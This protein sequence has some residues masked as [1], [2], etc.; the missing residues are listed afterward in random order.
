MGWLAKHHRNFGR[1]ALFAMAL[2]LIAAFGHIHAT[3]TAYSPA[4]STI[5]SPAPDHDDGAPAT[6][7]CAICA[8]MHLAGTLDLPAVAAVSAP[9]TTALAWSPPADRAIAPRPAASFRARGPPQA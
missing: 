1:L 6:T 4:L 7:D 9:E 2:Q 8:V 3:D 5:T